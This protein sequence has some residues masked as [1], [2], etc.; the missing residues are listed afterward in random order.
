MI[1]EFNK[2]KS[3]SRKTAPHARGWSVPDS[4][5]PAATRKRRVKTYS[6][7]QYEMAVYMTKGQPLER[8]KVL[9]RYE[10][11]RLPYLQA[12]IDDR[13]TLVRNA[14]RK[15]RLLPELEKRVVP[16]RDR[17]VV[18]NEAFAAEYK[19]DR[20]FERIQPN[21]TISY[22]HIRLLHNLRRIF[23]FD[24]FY[25]NV[26][27]YWFT[28][29]CFYCQEYLYVQMT[30]YFPILDW[31][32]QIPFF[33][34]P[35]SFEVHLWRLIL[36]FMG[37]TFLI[38]IV[39]QSFFNQASVLERRLNLFH[40][41][42]FFGSVLFYYLTGLVPFIFFI[43]L[44]FVILMY[45]NLLYYLPS[46]SSRS[47][48]PAPLLLAAPSQPVEYPKL[49]I[50]YY[51]Y[52]FPVFTPA[53][54]QSKP[55]RFTHFPFLTVSHRSAAPKYVFDLKRS[56][57]SFQAP[58]QGGQSSFFNTGRFDETF[59]LNPY[60]IYERYRFERAH[61]PTRD[62]RGPTYLTYNRS[63]SLRGYIE[64]PRH[65]MGGPTR[66]PLGG[67]IVSFF[68]AKA[69]SPVSSIFKDYFTGLTSRDPLQFPRSSRFTHQ[70]LM[71]D[72][73]YRLSAWLKQIAPLYHAEIPQSRFQ[74]HFSAPKPE[75]VARRPYWLLR[76]F[77]DVF[78]EFFIKRLVNILTLGYFSNTPR[79]AK[80]PY[81]YYVL[82]LKAYGRLSFPSLV[83]RSYAHS[84]ARLMVNFAA[85]VERD[86]SLG[87]GKSLFYR[88]RW[89][90]YEVL[91]LLGALEWLLE[92]AY[93]SYRFSF[94]PSSPKSR[95]F[96]EAVLYLRLTVYL[97]TRP[98]F[99]NHIE[100]ERGPVEG[101][102]RDFMKGDL[103]HNE[104][105]KQI[106]STELLPLNDEEELRKSNKKP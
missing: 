101:L 52:P 14:R 7:P 50:F 24:Y 86:L 74:R 28:W 4:P 56:V 33:H 2:G 38:F 8:Y 29:F 49:P 72:P 35:V 43:F 80:T 100:L 15:K 105:F 67:S 47:P 46:V 76:A 1:F 82:L 20:G 63:P 61:E 78:Y 94:A 23:V 30:M 5:A 104:I 6:D 18:K 22:F 45:Y 44:T 89:L 79:D 32:F 73:Y 41:I 68:E 21:I 48:V 59:N 69:S 11:Q 90:H 97:L 17:I 64:F 19:V 10:Y 65:L 54:S 27:W 106:F 55:K 91:T 81:E 60:E 102:A 36:V 26:F 95:F 99:E 25:T 39:S 40:F 58:W 75:S 13:T 88:D 83:S 42:A 16:A 53:I 12:S 3:V 103:E 34:W 96:D 92:T 98:P 71:G 77:F 57:G 62:N 9:H 70:R 66:E 37:L 84:L 93:G 87:R 85:V 31:F 51:H